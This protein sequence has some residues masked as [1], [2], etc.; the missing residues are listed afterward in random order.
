MS[1]FVES[2]GKCSRRQTELILK[3]SASGR[4]ECL[5]NFFVFFYIIQ[6]LRKALNF[7]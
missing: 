4:E 6:M 2:L 7:A 1:T 5:F 3:K